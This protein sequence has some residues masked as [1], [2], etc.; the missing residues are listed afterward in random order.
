MYGIRT[1]V[2]AEP[3]APIPKMIDTLI[4]LGLVM[5]RSHTSD[6]GKTPRIQSAAALTAE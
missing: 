5:F 1:I 4:L 6:I 2:A 3:S